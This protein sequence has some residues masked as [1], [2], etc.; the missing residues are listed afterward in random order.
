MDVKH[1]LVTCCFN[2]I[3][4]NDINENGNFERLFHNTSPNRLVQYINSNDNYKSAGYPNDPKI[5]IRDSYA[6]SPYYCPSTRKVSKLSKWE[7]I[8]NCCYQYPRMKPQD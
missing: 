5:H 4:I 2:M 3:K 6:P 8:L 7:S 1:V